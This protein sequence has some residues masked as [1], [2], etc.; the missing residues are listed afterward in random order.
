MV[1]I[2]AWIAGG[3]A[4][5]ALCACTVQPGLSNAPR[6]GTAPDAD[7]HIHDAIANG[8][9][10]CGRKLDP[11]PLRNR[12]VPCPRVSAPNSP[13]AP[14]VSLDDTAIMQWL[15]HY[16]ARWPCEGD[17]NP[18]LALA[19]GTACPAMGLEK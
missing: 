15:K 10:S 6:L 1:H 19:S 3:L 16:H 8:P 11:G 13:P 14:A 9:D 7:S 12:V 5:A 18:P 4:I 17:T 2:L